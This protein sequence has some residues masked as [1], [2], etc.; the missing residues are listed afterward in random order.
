MPYEAFLKLGPM[1]SFSG[2]QGICTIRNFVSMTISGNKDWKLIPGVLMT[3][4][5]PKRA[6]Y[7]VPAWCL[8]S[9]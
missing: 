5:Q 9:W 6:T 8:H 3:T 1:G 7:V 4:S 2:A